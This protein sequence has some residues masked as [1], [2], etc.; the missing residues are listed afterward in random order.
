MRASSELPF[1]FRSS[2]L[3]CRSLAEDVDMEDEATFKQGASAEVLASLRELVCAWL[4]PET[5]AQHQ[6]MKRATRMRC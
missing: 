4:L 2:E 1:E 5:Y 3:T 6:K